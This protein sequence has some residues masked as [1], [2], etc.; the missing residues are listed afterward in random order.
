MK[1]VFAS[2]YALS[3]E[4]L[5]RPE[6][7]S[8]TEHQVSTR[9]KAEA[10]VRNAIVLPCMPGEFPH[11]HWFFVRVFA[12]NYVNRAQ[13]FVASSVMLDALNCVERQYHE[14]DARIEA[15][16]QDLHGVVGMRADDFASAVRQL[17]A[18]TSY[19]EFEGKSYL[20]WI[21]ER[22]H[23]Y[24]NYWDYGN[25]ERLLNIEELLRD[26]DFIATKKTTKLKGIGLPLTANFFADLGLSVFAKPDLHTVPIINLLS[27]SVETKDIPRNSFREL[28]RIAQL[29]RRKLNTKRDFNWLAGGLYPRQLDRMIYLIGSDDFFLNGKQQKKYMAPQRR[30]LM[31]NVLVAQGILSSEYYDSIF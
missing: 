25:G 20:D 8:L 28:L 14:L 26:I 19:P 27:L 18:P 5:T 12:R 15:L 21:Q 1:T 30:V 22:W 16:I 29:E 9:E 24:Q 17:T 13:P 31:R 23:Y 6:Y 11:D 2:L 7:S 4:L 10:L 3:I